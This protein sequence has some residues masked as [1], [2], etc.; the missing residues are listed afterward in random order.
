MPSTIVLGALSRGRFLFL[1][2]LALILAAERSSNPLTMALFTAVATNPNNSIS[3]VT[4]NVSTS[5]SGSSFFTL[6]NM[7][8][9]DFSVAPITI[10]NGGTTSNQ[11]FTY[12][13]T[14]AAV[15]GQ[16]SALDQTAPNA[17]GTGGAALLIFRC[18]SDAAQTT[19][20]ACN[21][22]NVYITQVYP[23]AGAGTQVRVTATGG[24]TSSSTAFSSPA[25]NTGSG[26]FSVGIQGTSFTGGAIVTGAFPMGGPDSVTG[27]DSF[28]QTK[29]LAGAATSHSDYLATIIYLPS[30]TG[31]SLAGL[32]STI[33]FTWTATQRAGIGR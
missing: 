12:T 5:A 9:G 31:N 21:T 24:L 15:S 17:S 27:A 20:V 16:T 7:V 33:N 29:G 10:T 32:S 6:S 2:G 11:S 22:T 4:L 13:V 19:P 1:V 28:A 26:N 23:S 18:T 3:T 25:V 14:S 8:P 30:Q